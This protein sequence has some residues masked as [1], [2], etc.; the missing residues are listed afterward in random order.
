MHSGFKIYLAGMVISFLGSLPLG[1]LNISAMQIAVQES[2][3]KALAFSLGVALVELCYVRLSLTGIDL[4][5]ANQFV[6]YVLEWIT[7]ALFLILAASSFWIAFRNKSNQKSILLNNSVNRLWLGVS[8]SAVNP[9][10]IPFWFFW[11]TYLFSI[12]VLVSDSAAFNIFT[13]GAATGTIGALLVFV[14]GGKWV[15]TRLKAG[16]R[17]INWIVATVFLISA[18]IQLHRVLT[19]PF[20]KTALLHPYSACSASRL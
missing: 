7:V 17:T 20:L 11:S 3:K 2:V 15:V 8:M 16:E 1:T 4:V 10:Q 13:I 12:H 5:L 6:F 9:V 18:L 19:Q 14:Y